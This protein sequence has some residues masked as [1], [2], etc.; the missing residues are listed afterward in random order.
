MGA[1]ACSRAEAISAGARPLRGGPSVQSPG[2][3]Q[4]WSGVGF[5]SECPQTGWEPAAFL[6]GRLPGE[7]LTEFQVLDRQLLR[8][9]R[10]GVSVHW[11]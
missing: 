1:V 3:S 2:G 11:G 8:R 9:L 5:V 10:M 4:A 7:P 6:A